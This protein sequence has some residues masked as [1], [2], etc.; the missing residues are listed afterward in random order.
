MGL[1]SAGR[2]GEGMMKLEPRAARRRAAMFMIFAAALWWLE[3]M[4]ALLVLAFVAWLI[5][6]TRFEGEY[7]DDLRRAR[8]RFWPPASIV[9][10]ALIVAGTAVYYAS[11]RTLEAKMLPIALNVVALF[12]LILGIRWP[13][14][15][16]RERSAVASLPS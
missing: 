2:Y 7:G 10:I 15:A 11:N 14:A 13:V 16:S 5:V 4:P 6:H 3:W 12:T 8:Q 1:G 9:L